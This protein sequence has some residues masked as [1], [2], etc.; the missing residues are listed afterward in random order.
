MALVPVPAHAQT[1]EVNGQSCPGAAVVLTAAGGLTFVPPSCNGNGNPCDSAVITYSLNKISIQAP[2]ACL[3]AGTI[4]APVALS[5]VLVDGIACGSATVTFSEGGIAI[6]APT[7]C[8]SAP[9]LAPEILNFNLSSAYAGQFLTISGNYF[10]AGST[11]TVG[12]VAATVF[13]T[14]GTSSLVIVVPVVATGAQPVVVTSGSQSSTPVSINISPVPVPVTLLGVV[15]R[16]V[17]GGAGTFD[18]PIDYAQP[19]GGP[20]TVE[21][22]RPGA[23]HEIVFRFDLP[24]TSI[25]V[26]T[27][28]DSSF[29]PVNVTSQISGNDVI[30]TWAA[31]TDN[32]RI[33]ISLAAINGISS[34]AASVGFLMGDVNGSRAIDATDLSVVKAFSGQTTNALNFRN[35]MKASGTVNAANIATV[36]A[37]QGVTLGP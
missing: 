31:A 4:P 36:K 19:L 7:S 18:L 26:V 22:R 12:G 13:S 34:A 9:P 35:D 23:G 24:V 30:V 2:P 11:V 5:N 27:A 21:P 8:V 15:S 17:H 3:A 1:V 14:S 37:R 33:R 6:D 29:F 16:K 28:I 10:A 32:R 20:V 25:G